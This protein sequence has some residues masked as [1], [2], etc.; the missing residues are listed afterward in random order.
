V[1]ERAGPGAGVEIEH[2][3]G[4]RERFYVLG[5]W[6][7]DEA[8]GIISS[9]T[10]FAQAVEGHVAGDEIVVPGL[11]G[12]RPVRMVAVLPLS[13]EVRAWVRGGT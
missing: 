9:D 12:D 2:A 1:P 6:D 3:D 5:A 7:R 11:D 8:L 13:N 4:R 10:R